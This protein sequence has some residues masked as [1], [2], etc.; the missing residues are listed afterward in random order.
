MFCTSRRCESDKFLPPDMDENKTEMS[1]TCMPAG[2]S[3][4]AAAG[5]N[6]NFVF[7]SDCCGVMSALNITYLLKLVAPVIRGGTSPGPPVPHPPFQISTI[8]NVQGCQFQ[9]SGKFP[10]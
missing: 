5:K 1:L 9:I 2:E 7:G 3:A 6:S 10:I 4:P 8:L